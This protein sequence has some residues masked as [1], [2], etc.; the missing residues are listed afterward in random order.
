MSKYKRSP[1]CIPYR[2]RIEGAPA[3]GE[4]ESPTAS[5]LAYYAL[6]VCDLCEDDYPAHSER[7]QALRRLRGLAE[8]AKEGE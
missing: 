4:W 6:E 5:Q 2:D 3:V 7:G 1:N 8:D